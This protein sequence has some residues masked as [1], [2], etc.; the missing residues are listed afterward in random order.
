MQKYIESIQP[1]P[2][3]ELYD[4]IFNKKR[5]NLNSNYTFLKIFLLKTVLDITF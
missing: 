3:N 4:Y 2:L 5:Y 1:H